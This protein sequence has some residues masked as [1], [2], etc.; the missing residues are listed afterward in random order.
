[1]MRVAAI[2]LLFTCLL[3]SI[4]KSGSPFRFLPPTI[5]SAYSFFAASF[6]QRS[7]FKLHG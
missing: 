2:Y 3:Y 7:A 6:T 4:V 1:M 5:C